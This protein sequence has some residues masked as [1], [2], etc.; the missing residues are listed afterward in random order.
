MVAQTNQRRLIYPASSD[1]V[2]YHRLLPDLDDV[3]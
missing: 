1:Q 3:D 2:A